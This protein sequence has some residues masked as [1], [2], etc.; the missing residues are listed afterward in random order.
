MIVN[1]EFTVG[2]GDMLKVRALQLGIPM[3]DQVPEKEVLPEGVVKIVLDGKGD[4]I[5]LPIFTNSLTGESVGEPVML[6]VQ[7]QK[8]GVVFTN[9]LGFVNMIQGDLLP[10]SE[11]KIV[12]KLASQITA[13]SASVTL[14]ST[15]VGGWKKKGDKDCF[16][17]SDSNIVVGSLDKPVDP[18]TN[19]EIDGSWSLWPSVGSVKTVDG[20]LEASVTCLFTPT[21]ST[22]YAKLAVVVP[23]TAGTTDNRSVG[24]VPV[25]AWSQLTEANENGIAIEV[26]ESQLSLGLTVT[27]GTPSVNGTTVTQ[28]LT[29]TAG[30]PVEVSEDVI[31]G[32][33]YTGLTGDRIL[34]AV[35]LDV[36]EGSESLQVVDT[37]SGGIGLASD[38][39]IKL[40]KGVLLN[41]K[42]VHL[43]TPLKKTSN[44]TVLR[45]LKFLAS[46]G[47][48]LQT[49]ALTIDASAVLT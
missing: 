6:A 14:S 1:G 8:I 11:L 45:T 18:S 36:P 23:V 10:A 5:G 22:K 13:S 29:V 9:G 43:L 2:Q 42:Q 34:V 20:T 41:G 7:E 28:T 27:G 47:S 48:T 40:T 49:Q 17:A 26:P 15:T 31:Q 3:F 21:D 25:T 38:R 12:P 35:M 19:A 32:L 33:G 39:T 37:T 24:V 30:T 16:A 44:D 46:D 4:P